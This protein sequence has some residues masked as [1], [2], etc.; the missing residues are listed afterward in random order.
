MRTK[1]GRLK[2]GEAEVC[3][4]QARQ[5]GLRA[6]Q[7]EGIGGRSVHHLVWCLRDPA[8]GRGLKRACR[9]AGW[10]QETRGTE[11]DT[12]PSPLFSPSL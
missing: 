2:R 4:D 11:A 7:W 6:E 8:G 9:R 10:E 12:D 5:A 1:A 3:W